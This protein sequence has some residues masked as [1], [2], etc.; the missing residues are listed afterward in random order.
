MDVYTRIFIHFIFGID[1]VL[2]C[3]M[4]WCVFA[5]AKNII[6]REGYSYDRPFRGILLLQCLYFLSANSEALKRH[7]SLF[8]FTPGYI[9]S[10]EN[11]ESLLNDR[12]GMLFTGVCA[13]LFT[14]KWIP[15]W[16]KP[17]LK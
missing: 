3:L 17:L 14:L 13:F 1:V 8:F 12:G 6:L 10:R 15:E 4:A 7:L 5:N 16:F 11:A 9:L 2:V